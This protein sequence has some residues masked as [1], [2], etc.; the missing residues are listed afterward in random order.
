M[1]LGTIN[2]ESLMNLSFLRL[3]DKW[4]KLFDLNTFFPL[5]GDLILS[6]NLSIIF[7]ILGVIENKFL[8]FTD[9]YL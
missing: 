3:K 2:A 8:F 4:R 5:K 9:G 1:M 7:K 6:L